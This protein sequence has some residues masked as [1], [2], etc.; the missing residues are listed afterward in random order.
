LPSGQD[1][2]LLQLYIGAA[3]DFVEKYTNRGLIQ[4][5]V[6][7][8]LD[9]LNELKYIEA[10]LSPIVTTQNSVIGIEDV[11]IVEIDE[12]GDENS[13]ADIILYVDTS[14]L[15]SRIYLDQDYDLETNPIGYKII[16]EVGEADITD[17]DSIFQNAIVLMVAEVYSN[18]E[19][20]TRT[21]QTLAD[22][23]LQ[24]YRI[25]YYE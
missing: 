9:S 24:P 13:I 20:P 19:N 8:R 15:P 5:E 14:V 7:F 17:I 16:Y 6:T 1:S 23:Y 11:D 3:I 4:Q 25:H 22:K 21:F 12:T 10:K 2:T 18:R